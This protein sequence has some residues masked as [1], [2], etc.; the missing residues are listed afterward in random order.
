MG[1]SESH[2]IIVHHSLWPKGTKTIN[3]DYRI[4]ATEVDN[5]TDQS[6]K[7]TGQLAITCDGKTTMKT[8]SVNVSDG[9][10]TAVMDFTFEIVTRHS[11]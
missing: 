11:L 9:S 2:N 1:S 4:V 5:G 8:I 3:L 7:A 10:T 6:G